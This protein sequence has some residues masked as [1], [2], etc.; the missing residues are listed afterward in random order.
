MGV[1]QNGWFLLGK[2]HLWLWMLRGYPHD[3]GN[4]HISLLLSPVSRIWWH[5]N[6]PQHLPQ[7]V[8]MLIASPYSRMYHD[9]YPNW[10]VKCPMTWV[11]WTSPE[12]VAI[13]DH[14]PIME[15]NGWV[16]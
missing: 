9:L 15:S 1:P 4:H 6:N 12:K 10:V 11:Y 2:N 16:M 7:Q 3:L 8:S 14:I 5:P 13:I